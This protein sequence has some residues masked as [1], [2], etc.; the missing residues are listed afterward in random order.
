MDLSPKAEPV[1]WATVI[2]LALSAGVSYGLNITQELRDFLVIATPVIF[3]ALVARFAVFSPKT[4]EEDYV[5]AP[6]VPEDQWGIN[7]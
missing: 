3:T 6:K 1:A 2:G 4:V 7:R 5:K